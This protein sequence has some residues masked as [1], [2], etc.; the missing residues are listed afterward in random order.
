MMKKVERVVP[1]RDEIYVV[2]THGNSVDSR[3][4]GAISTKALVGKV[5]WHIRS[6]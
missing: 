5:I 1:D 6:R 4:F 2:G 3:Q